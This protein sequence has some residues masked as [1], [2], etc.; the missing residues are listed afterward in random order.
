MNSEPA[1]E[2]VVLVTG[3]GGGLGRALTASFA[4][5]NW[6]V[7]AA[8]HRSVPDFDSP[9]VWPC[10]L[11][12]TDPGAAADLV[13]MIVQRWGR[14]DALVNNAGITSDVVVARMRDEDWDRAMDVN[15][16][17][18]FR[19][20]RAAL[21][22]MLTRG[23]GHVLSIGSHAGVRGAAGQAN[24]AAAK[25][26]LIGWTRS[27]AQELGPQGICANVVLPGV[28]DTAM[29]RVLSS[30]VLDRFKEDNVLGRINTVEEVARTVVTLAGLRHVSS[31]V[32]ALDGRIGTWPA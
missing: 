12:V 17:G 3:A 28:M 11:D 29:T 14:L 10:V 15:L 1:A 6:R 9:Q 7:A 4:A 32:W 25:A 8:G 26:A 2:R 19:C 5:A 31:Q 24:Y 22:A 20:T 27:I 21:P 23:A 30:S 16:K 18:A 13:G